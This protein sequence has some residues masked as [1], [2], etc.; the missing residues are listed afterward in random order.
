MKLHYIISALLITALFGCMSC[1]N[2]ET[3]PKMEDGEHAE[4]TDNKMDALNHEL[5]TVIDFYANWCPPCKAIAPHFH[6]MK[7][8][9]SGTLNMISVNVDE[10]VAL[11]RRYNVQ[12]IPTFIFLDKEGNLSGRIVG[13]DYHALENAVK[14]IA[15]HPETKF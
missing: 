1:I 9:Y 7:E 2:K 12:S 11:A 13:A 3:N 10:N 4:T 15:A 6:K 8:Q 5:P 14:E